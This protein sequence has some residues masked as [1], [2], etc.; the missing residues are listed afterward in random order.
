[1]NRILYH[2]LALT[3]FLMAVPS[4]NAQKTNTSN[5]LIIKGKHFAS[6]IRVF[7]NNEQLP[8]NNVTRKSATELE[9]TLP[10]DY[11]IPSATTILA[12]GKNA[13]SILTSNGMVSITLRNPA[14]SQGVSNARNV[15]LKTV[16]PASVYLTETSVITEDK[17]KS[18]GNVT[19]RVTEDKEF[20]TVALKLWYKD[21]PDDEGKITVS[22]TYE[23]GLPVPATPKLFEMVDDE[24]D[25]ITEVITP[26]PSGSQLVKLK[27]YR[28]NKTAGSS[29][30][31]YRFRIRFT[32]GNLD[33]SKE[34]SV[35]ARVIKEYIAI[36]PFFTAR[37]S[38]T[39]FVEKNE[40]EAALAQLPST[41]R[42]FLEQCLDILNRTIDNLQDRNEIS[43]FTKT[44]FKF[45]AA[46][47]LLSIIER[48]PSGNPSEYPNDHLHIDIERLKNIGGGSDITPVLLLV[49]SEMIPYQAIVS[50]CS[51][52]KLPAYII[53]E[54][55]HAINLININD[56]T[57]PPVENI[58]WNQLQSIIN[59][60][61]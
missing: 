8:T 60:R 53:V 16:S 12:K 34:V 55:K 51:E 3:L 42:I 57:K 44:R 48:A 29:G 27:F 49:N 14:P 40:D 36:K 43:K 17:S 59:A 24:D 45:Q 38:Q 7:I 54:A 52:D 23:N 22:M 39:F 19:I 41:P 56:A 33:V 31:V 46:P 50:E 35:N 26:E 61:P 32:V 21:M 28:Q 18:V 9:V 11:V 25:R 13:G 10:P 30:S 37:S 47:S 5:I 4:I 15:A 1:M 58:F 6:G 2:I 20:E